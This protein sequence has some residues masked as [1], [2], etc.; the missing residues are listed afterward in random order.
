MLDAFGVPIVVNMSRVK[1]RKMR[2]E[3]P[4]HFWLDVDGCWFCD[5]HNGC[6][7]CKVIKR[8]IAEKQLTKRKVA[9]DEKRFLDNS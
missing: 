9:R 2:P 4:K 5:N 3:P 7:G 8:Y 6:S 1:R